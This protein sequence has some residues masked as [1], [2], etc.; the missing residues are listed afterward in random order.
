MEPGSCQRCP[1]AGPGAGPSLEPLRQQV[2]AWH[3]LPA[4]AGGLLLE[5]LPEPP[6][7]GAGHQLGG[8]AGAGLGPEG[9]GALLLSAICDSA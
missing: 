8:P 2:G 9:P 3:R 6:G 4:E 7:R 1:G 5:G